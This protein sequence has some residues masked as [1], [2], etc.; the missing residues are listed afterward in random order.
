MEQ[1]L[2]IFFWMHLRHTAMRAF[3]ALFAHGRSARNFSNFSKSSEQNDCEK[4]RQIR[5]N[6]MLT[7]LDAPGA[8]L[9]LYRFSSLPNVNDLIK[10]NFAHGFRPRVF[11]YCMNSKIE[12]CEI[13]VFI[14]IRSKIVAKYCRYRSEKIPE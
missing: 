13:L 5:Q 12:W 7:R 6:R 3:Y 11:E 14:G 2:F 4:K 1:P 8:R 9:V 10:A